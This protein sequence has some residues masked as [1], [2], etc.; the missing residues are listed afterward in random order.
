MRPTAEA[1]GQI[2]GFLFVILAAALIVVNTLCVYRYARNRHGPSSVVLVPSILG[3]LGLRLLVGD[4]FGLFLRWALVIIVL[5]FG[6]LL[7][8]AAIVR[9]RRR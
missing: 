9:L 1:V 3:L 7:V 6:P 5:D 2:L 8:T 4:D